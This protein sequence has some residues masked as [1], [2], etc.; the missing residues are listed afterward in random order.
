MNHTPPP[1]DETPQVLAQVKALEQQAWKERTLDAAQSVVLANQALTLLSTLSA[2]PVTIEHLVVES[3]VYFALGCAEERLSDYDRAFHSGEE[4]LCRAREAQDGF[5]ESEESGDKEAQSRI[6]SA[7]MKAYNLL[8]NVCDR[9]GDYA[10]ALEYRQADH[11]MAMAV[12]DTGQ[13]AHTLLR[14]GGSHYRLGDYPA[15]LKLFL[16][17]R[18]LFETT[19]DFA[20]LGSTWN[21]IGNLHFSEE[22]WAEAR[23]AYQT[24]LAQFRHTSDPYW[25]SGL[26]YNLAG[27]HLKQDNLGEARACLEESLHLREG[28]GD[29]YGQG[30]SLKSLAEVVRR[31]G[32]FD[33]AR[34]LGLQSRALFEQIGDQAGQALAG[35]ALAEIEAAC[36]HRELAERHYHESLAYTDA[37]G[38]REVSYQIHR[39][40]SQL[41]EGSGD[42]ERALSHYQQFHTIKEALFND[43]TSDKLRN[44][45]VR[46]R[47]AQTQ[48]ESA[49]LRAHNDE[50]SAANLRQA[51]LLKQLHDQSITLDRQARTDA[52]TSLLNRR[53]LEERFAIVH[54]N[55]R[56]HG[57]PLSVALMDLD[58][59]KRINDE[60]S[61]QMGDT[62][63]RTVARLLKQNCRSGDILAR[64]G[65]EEF[66]LVLPET[67]R[68]EATVFCEQMR[69][70]VAAFPWHD[71][72]PHLTVTLSLGLCSD[73]AMMDP[74]QMLSCADTLLYEAKAAGRNRVFA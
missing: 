63:L 30:Y 39:E 2:A 72:H 18:A 55:A 61:H 66:V 1:P 6:Y 68:A 31:E 45:E 38:L 34:T 47:V 33:H 37:Q 13:Q 59:F 8:G 54:K 26:L 74:E 12:G 4:A 11:A 22:H 3:E 43:T 36:G 53:S 67:A 7:C 29:R 70:L 17:A 73:P 48:R 10:R 19:D 42:F 9:R 51:T 20:G 5:R 41:Y 24:A 25:Q 21:G 52:L 16:E 46:H 50:L 44:L 32:D 62:V 56:Q 14:L 64:Y 57:L 65:G 28:I 71:L 35:I 23:D 27:I 15:A 49:I 40:L 69:H 58:H 60:F